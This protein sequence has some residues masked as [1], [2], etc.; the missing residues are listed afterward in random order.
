MESVNDGVDHIREGAGFL[1]YLRPAA[2]YLVIFT[3]PFAGGSVRTPREEVVN[4]V[5]QV[6]GESVD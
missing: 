2:V 5:Y 1:A 3:R 4:R 6:P